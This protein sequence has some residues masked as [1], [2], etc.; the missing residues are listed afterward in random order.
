VDQYLVVIV[1]KKK[2]NKNK[3]SFFTPDK[4]VIT[5]LSKAATVCQIYQ[6]P[7]ARKVCLGGVHLM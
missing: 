2:K 5:K 7:G 3:P 6:P 4:E 1:K